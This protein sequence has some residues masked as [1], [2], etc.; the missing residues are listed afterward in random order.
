MTSRLTSGW[1][2]VL[3]THQEAHALV[4]FSWPVAGFWKVPPYRKR[5]LQRNLVAWI[6]FPDTQALSLLL[7]ADVGEELRLRLVRQHRPV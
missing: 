6:Y 3:V 1:H 2:H 7:D 4:L 5:L